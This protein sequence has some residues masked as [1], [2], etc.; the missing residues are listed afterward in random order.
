[1]WDLTIQPL[2]GSTSSSAH[3]WAG[4]GSD[5]I[6]HILAWVHHIPGMF[7]HHSTILSALGSDYALTVLFLGTQTRTSPVGH[8]SWECSRALLA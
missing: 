3:F 6:C 4:I 2:R 1:M 7:H 8:S 5:T